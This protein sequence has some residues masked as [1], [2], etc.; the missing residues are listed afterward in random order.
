MRLL[1]I[2]VITC[3]IGCAA[4][5][6][7]V[8]K[9]VP[10]PVSD[11]IKLCELIKSSTEAYNKCMDTEADC[12]NLKKELY[13]TWLLSMHRV[14]RLGKNCKTDCKKLIRILKEL[15]SKTKK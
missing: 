2:A 7:Q 11:E 15:P 9:P 12:E 4:K 10:L 14:R 13:H 3:M 1:L 6:Q 5:I 8:T